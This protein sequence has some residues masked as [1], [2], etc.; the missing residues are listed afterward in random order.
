MSSSNEITCRPRAALVAKSREYPG[1]WKSMDRARAMRGKG[2]GE[3]PDCCFLPLSATVELVK[4]SYPEAIYGLDFRQ[5]CRELVC[6]NAL[7]AWR[8][9]QGVYRFDSTVYEEV[10]NTP[11]EGNIPTSVLCHLP[12]WC[13][14]I[15][16]PELAYFGELVHGV[17]LYVDWD[18]VTDTCALNIVLD[19]P[20]LQALYVD[21]IEEPLAQQIER[22]ARPLAEQLGVDNLIINAFAVSLSS[23]LNSVLAL[24]LYLCAQN[25]EIGDGTCR[26]INPTPKRIKG[27]ESRLFPP[28]GITTWGVGV[29]LGAALRTAI[30]YASTGEGEANAR[31]APRGH[32]RRAHWHGFR[33]GP[34]KTVD[35]QAICTADRR[36]KVRWQPPLAINLGD[37]SDLP[38]TIRTVN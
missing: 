33:L 17:W 14:Y 10:R 36:F 35:G 37:L 11:F 8:V 29:R 6:I 21:L 26:P 22:S 27:G 31:N 34:T 28:N 5:R 18:A 16:T 20:R 25:A 24:A 3:W 38:S 15:E 7:A 4:Q 23:F 30:Q 1:L 2:Q 12:E 19:T 32:I 13:V 9:T